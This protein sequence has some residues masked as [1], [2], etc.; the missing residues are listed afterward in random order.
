MP[1]QDMEITLDPDMGSQQQARVH[2]TQFKGNP[3]NTGSPL[4]PGKVQG[5]K[6]YC[7]Q[8]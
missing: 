4:F 5:I 8:V 7:T 2:C 6:L 3:T 1:Q